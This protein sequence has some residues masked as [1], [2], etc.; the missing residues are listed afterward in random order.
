[1]RS[2]IL[3][4]LA[5]VHDAKLSQRV[6]DLALEKRLHGNEVLTPLWT[7]IGAIETRDRAWAWM[8]DHFD[9]I[10]DQLASGR[11]GALPGLASR[12]CD[13]AHRAEIES[14]FRPRVDKLEGG[15]RNLAL[16][17]ESLDLCVARRK[18]QEPALRDFFK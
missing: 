13:D 11:A 15:P 14:F 16:G 2:R 7:Q 8:R 18:D 6:L 12:F 17:L 1:M 10:F 3:G 4:A 9:A 5:S